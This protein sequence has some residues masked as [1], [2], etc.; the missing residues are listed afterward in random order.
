MASAYSWPSTIDTPSR[1]P[2]EF[3]KSWPQE[4]PASVR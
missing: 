4:A 1:V 3:T 2:F